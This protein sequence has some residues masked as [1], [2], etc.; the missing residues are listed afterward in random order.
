MFLFIQLTTG[1]VNKKRKHAKKLIPVETVTNDFS[2][3]I[4]ESIDD[5]FVIHP[6]IYTSQPTTVSVGTQYNLNDI[7][8][9]VFPYVPIT[10]HV[11]GGLTANESEA[12]E[13]CCGG[14]LLKLIAKDHCYT[15]PIIPLPESADD[16]SDDEKVNGVVRP[17][18]IPLEEV[19]TIPAAADFLV[20]DLSEVE[21]SSKTPIE[22]IDIVPPKTCVTPADSENKTTTVPE[23]EYKYI[24]FEQNLLQLLKHCPDCGAI[25]SNIEKQIS[26]SLLKIHYTCSSG[27]SGKWLSQS[28]VRSMA[29]GNLLLPAAILLTGSSYTKVSNMFDLL[30]IPIPSKTTFYDVQ[31]TYLHPVINNY[32]QLHQTAL[33]SEICSL[34]VRLCGDARSDSPGYSAKYSSYSLMD[35]QSEMIVAQELVQVTEAGNSVAMELMGLDRCMDTIIDHG[36]EIALI[37]TD[38]H[39]GVQCYL[40]TNF[41]AINHQ[42]DVWH[43]AKSITKKLVKKAQSPECKELMPWVHSISNHLYYCAQTCGSD[44]E[45]LKEKWISLAHH[46]ANNHTWIG[47]TMIGCEHGA[48]TDSERAETDWLELNS[49]AHNALKDVIF[50]KKLL[51]DIEKLSQFCHTGSLESYH[52]MLLKYVPKRQHYSHAGMNARLQL[53]ALDHNHNV[54]RLVAVKKDGSEILSQVF[55]KM[56]KT[57]VVKNVYEK[58]SYTYLNELMSRVVERR[59]DDTINIGDINIRVPIPALPTNIA[60]KPKPDKNQAI[61]ERFSRNLRVN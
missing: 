59:L 12:D 53:A 38:R 39:I 41:P 33:L 50:N 47:E 20:V 9:T 30:N 44:A 16:E 26:G 23:Q 45:V 25:V 48:L 10:T 7:E 40:R 14:S 24:V 37:A 36:A 13:N 28:N 56:R 2:A 17:L 57:W 58:K 52:A 1:R 61:E 55:S 18:S 43:I 32:W 6:D 54:G 8:D 42:F 27:H 35:M 60:T 19:Q 31:N 29:A 34:P 46:I 4:I 22:V 49:A 51:K 11:E 3:A 15:R 5:P 21:V